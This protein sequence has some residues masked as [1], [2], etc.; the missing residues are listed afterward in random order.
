MDD[1][2]P[3]DEQ[4][5]VLAPLLP[6]QP[7]TGRR[8]EH[9]R[10]VLSSLVYQLKTGVRYRN[11]PRAEDYAANSTVYH[12]LG[13]W[14]E[15]GVLERIWRQV[16]TELKVRR[17]LDLSQGSLDGSSVPAKRGARR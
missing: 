7:R 17:E 10:Q 14:S 13:K 9:H 12:W 1:L 15:T 6:P 4:W 5:Q 16:L 11:I 2:K 3:G 8:R